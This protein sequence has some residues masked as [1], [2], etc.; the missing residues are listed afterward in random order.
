MPS[1]AEKLMSLDEFRIWERERPVFTLS[2]RISELPLDILYEDI[3][4]GTT[5]RPADGRP[6]PAA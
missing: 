2:S 6:A 3:E 4:F 5:R 1:T